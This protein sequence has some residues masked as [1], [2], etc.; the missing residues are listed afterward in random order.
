V[1]AAPDFLAVEDVLELHEAQLL[2]FGGGSGVRDRNALES[3]VAQ[4]QATFDGVF[5]HDDLFRMASAYAFHIA[6]N[7]P[8]VDG[9]KRT[10][11][12]AALVFLDLHGIDVLDP[13]A[14]LYQAFLEIAT[15][16][17]DKNGLAGLLQE[18][19]RKVEPLDS[20]G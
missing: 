6:Q 19:S 17:L 11:L 8:F 7:Q 10:A 18:L 9:N 1:S 13:E 2:R 3:A 20:G 15:G 4:A 14:K 5:L 16:E 12:A